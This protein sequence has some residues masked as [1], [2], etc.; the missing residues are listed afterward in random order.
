MTGPTTEDIAKAMA[1]VKALRQQ[2]KETRERVRQIIAELIEIRMETQ[3][4]T[5]RLIQKDSKPRELTPHEKLNRTLAFILGGA[6]AGGRI[7]FYGL[8]GV[9]GA[10][11]I[12][13]YALYQGTKPS[14]E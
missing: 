14:K 4:T 8:L 12:P 9:G 11:G 6:S 5:L 10:I 7:G 1:E 13:G 2:C 3:R